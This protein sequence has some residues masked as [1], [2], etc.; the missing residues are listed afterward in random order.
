MALARHVRQQVGL[1]YQVAPNNPHHA[2]GRTHIK[3]A[4]SFIVPLS[5]DPMLT[6][7]CRC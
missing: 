5:S 4:S 2:H 6:E 3:D 7:I 1:R